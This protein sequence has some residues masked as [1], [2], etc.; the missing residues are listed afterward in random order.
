MRLML[1][2]VILLALVGVALAEDWTTTDGKTYKHVKVIK[3]EDDAVTILDEDGGALV[4]L[5]VLP[6]ALQKQFNYDP[7]KAAA[8]AAQR[9][10]ADAA[11]TQAVADAQ[12]KEK[13]QEQKLQAAM[14]AAAAAKP[15]TPTAPSLSPSATTST[16]PA[17]TPSTSSSSSST[18][19]APTTG[20]QFSLNNKGLV[21]VASDTAHQGYNQSW[22]L[23]WSDEFDGP[24]LD[25]T[26]WNYNID[27][28][29]EGNGEKEYYTDSPKNTHIEDGMLHIT[30]IK[31]DGHPFTSARI[32]TKG[33]F[34]WKYGRFEARIKLPKGKGCWPA[35]WLMPEDSAY[36]GW[37]ASGE[38]DIMEMVGGQTKEGFDG[39]ATTWG[40]IHYGDK[41]PKNVHTG[42]HLICP[43]GKL[44]DDFHTYA[45]EWEN[46]VIRWYFDG[47]LYEEQVKWSTKS[48]PFPAPFDQ[49]FYVILNF[50]VGGAWP[51][52][53]DAGT[54]FPQD[55]VVDY[56][57][58]YQPADAG[59]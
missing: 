5:N 23:V 11:E 44:S 9:Q 24:D 43:T 2:S 6:P 27:G 35:F 14:A 30:A 25:T 16:A 55:M 59:N 10:N 7:A 13:D 34:S 3:V 50:A 58:V 41:W 1:F 48:A 18:S 49:K 56:V 46:G 21:D 12:A 37:A 38:L 32:D 53:P 22:K 17:P 4:P 47:Q 19:I 33:K 36:G 39:D 26:K 29:G 52:P 31:G 28:K 57:R 8:A 20:G 42:D 45:V 54:Q 51:G 15:V 40:T